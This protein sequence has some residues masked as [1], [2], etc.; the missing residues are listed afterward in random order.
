MSALEYVAAAAL[1]WLIG[2]LPLFE[3]YVAIPVGLA[4][5]LDPASATLWAAFGNIVPLYLVDLGYERLRRI[6]RVDHYLAK[7]RR[8]RVERIL[9]RW[10]WVAVFAAT[11]LL[12]VW[13]MA[14]AAKGLGMA[15]R[16]FLIAATISV[17]VY[18]VI[19]TLSIELGLELIGA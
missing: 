16:P 13:T 4:A 6:E 18:A 19:I 17:A 2:F 3:I 8:E 11:P 1:T 9:D 12:G 14:L 10:G 5:G 7:L 15:T